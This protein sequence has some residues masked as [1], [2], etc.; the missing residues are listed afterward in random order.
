M[1]IAMLK[2][3]RLT[4]C[5]RRRAAAGYRNSGGTS[6]EGSS[7]AWRRP[8]SGNVDACTSGFDGILYIEYNDPP[9]YHM[10]PLDLT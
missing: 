6:R 10:T 2:K 9:T 5:R 3:T 4:Q 7:I 1:P 8:G